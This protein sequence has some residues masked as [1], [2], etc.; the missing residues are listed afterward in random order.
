MNISRRS[1]LA[2]SAGLLSA[3]SSLD[4]LTRQAAGAGEAPTPTVT[5]SPV[6]L[7]GYGTLSGTFRTLH[8]G[9]SSLTH[10]VCESPRKRI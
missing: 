1:F 3:L 8:A 5:L 2:A 7:R 4:L 9:Q 10:I 6:T